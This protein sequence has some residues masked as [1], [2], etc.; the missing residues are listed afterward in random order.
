MVSQVVPSFP[1]SQIPNADIIQMGTIMLMPNCVTIVRDWNTILSSPL[2]CF[3]DITTASA[4]LWL[5]KH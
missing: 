2:R 1:S 5:F 3:M 4:V